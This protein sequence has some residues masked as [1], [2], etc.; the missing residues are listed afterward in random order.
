[1]PARLS[2]R[3]ALGVLGAFALALAPVAWAQAPVHVPGK[4]RVDRLERRR[5]NVEGNNL[6]ATITNWNQTGQSGQPGD[7]AYEYPKNSRRIYVSLSQLWVGGRVQ[8]TTG[9]LTVVDVADF[10][11]N[12]NGGSTAWTFQPIK[13]Y[14]NPAGSAFGV[15]QSDERTSWP[16]S[17]PDKLA[18]PTDP[19]WAGSWN[20]Y[21]GKNIFNAD[22]EFFWK[23]GDDQYDRYITGPTAVNNQY[24]PDETDRTRGGLGL[25]TDSRVLAWSQILIDDVVFLLYSIKND[26]TKD[27]PQA[28]VA[29][30]LAD[31]VGGDGA[32]D[33]PFFDIG[34]DVSFLTDSDGRGTQPFG[35]DP[36]GV[37]AIAYLETPGN[38]V[39]RIDNDGDGT[40]LTNPA[41]PSVCVARVGEC[42]SPLVT[43]ALIAGEDAANG[44]DDNGNGL[45]DESRANTPI[46]EA[47]VSSPGVGFADYVDNDDDGE[48][49]GPVVTQDMV[50]AAASD[51]WNR[52]PANPE[53]DPF[54]DPVRTAPGFAA[55]R[56]HL[57]GV[58]PEDLGKLFKDG[59]DNGDAAYTDGRY[60]Y[61]SEAN[62]PTV[63]AAM[64]TTAASD[65]ARRFIVRTADGAGVCA[66]LYG[67]GPEDVGR[68]YRDCVDNDADGATDEGIDENIDEMIDES[69]DDGIDNDGDWLAARDDNGLDG[70]AGSGDRGDGDANPT[71]GSGT[72][73]PGEKNVDKTDVSESDQI[74]ITNVQRIPAFTLN[75]NAQS[76]GLL[77]NTYMLPGDIETVIPPP[78]ENDL[79]VSSGLFPLRAGQTERISVA[80]AVGAS[81]TSNAANQAEVLRSIQNARDAYAADY[82][83]AQA[84]RLPTVTAVPGDGRVTLYWDSVAEESEDIYLAE[85]GFDPK[86]FEGYRIYR[87]TDPAFL[88]ALVITDGRGNL[89]YRRPI[90]QF[91]LRDGR[92]GFHPVDVNGVKFFLGDDTGLVHS[93]VDTTAVNG[94]TYYYAVTAYDF[95]VADAGISPTETPIRIQRDADG[96]ITVGPNVRAVTPQAPAAGYRGAEIKEIT[97]VAGAT[98]SRIGYRILD[99]T[100]FTPGRRY[101][102]TFDDTLRVGSSASV[103]DTLTTKSFTLTDAGTGEVLV[104]RSTAFRTAD[105]FPLF[106]ENGTSL[107]FALQFFPDP[108]V[109]PDPNTTGWNSQDVKPAAIDAY[110]A[111][112]FIKGIRNPTNYRVEILADGAGRS[113]ELVYRRNRTAPARPTNVRVVNTVTNQ[114]V[115]YA[116]LDFAGPNADL[117]GNSAVRFGADAVESDALVL[118]EPLAGDPSGAERVTWQLSL[119]NTTEFLNRRDPRQGDVLTFVTKKPFLGQDVFEFEVTPAT[120]APDSATNVLDAIRVVPNPYVAA[121]V[122]EPQN[123]FAQGRGERV[124]RFTRLPPSCTV[125]IFTVDGLLLKTLRKTDGANVSADLLNGTLTWDLRTDDNL[126]VSY[127]VYLY[128]VEAPGFGEKTGTFAIIK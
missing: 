87:A 109:V 82:Q 128:H 1:M 71:S 45:V 111:A 93:F 17:W 28:G 69:R 27:I 105:E 107:G 112:G 122:F 51:R 60:V 31:L 32:D 11:S 94:V 55:V 101:R 34:Q 25:V 19:G 115:K 104:N 76:D 30:W 12:G 102:V 14:V 26:G 86:D 24:Y 48:R 52:W 5:D 40:T 8:G 37:A 108:V 6:R 88:D 35:S 100:V 4:E 91:D 67:V 9:P 3:V 114:E 61:Q 56:V 29:L 97:R 47:G 123:P 16:A 72:T 50:S 23:T 125:R 78:G 116:F 21:F 118:I 18:D 64:E 46:N 13:G 79:V 77:F 20:G 58:G 90:A 74:G 66:I 83:F 119:N 63:T 113:T 80:V 110:L 96:K 89:T 70:V 95:G 7:I 84:P 54:L 33:V 42:G 92:R 38:A 2:R 49:G 73:F 126:T 53:T 59:I 99:P 15:A 22:Q 65:P 44:V 41:V 103:A 68:A 10:R 121:N 43:T 36:V 62:G 39:D 81:G 124:I 117:A 75:F 85:R 98:T 120:A 127:G 106:A 57:V